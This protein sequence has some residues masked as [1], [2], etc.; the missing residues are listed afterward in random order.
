V[1]ELSDHAWVEVT[2]APRYA[3]GGQ[4]VTVE[5]V[6]DATARRRVVLDGEPVSDSAWQVRHIV[7]TH[8][9]CVIATASQEPTEVQIVRFGFDGT[10]EPLTS[11]AA[12]HSAWVGGPTTVIARTDLASVESSVVVNGE[13]AHPIQVVSHPAPFTPSVQLL[14]AGPDEL[15][16]AVLFPRNH[17][18]GSL[19]LPILMNPYGGPHA[20]RVL[21][22]ARMFLEPQWLADQGFC[23]IVADGRGTPGRD[24]AWERTVLHDLATPA[25]H[26]QVTALSHV[27]DRFP[28][29]VDPNRVGIF[30][31]SFGGYLAALAV[32]RRPDV[33]HAAVAGAP[34]TEWRLY[35][36]AYTERYLGDPNEAPERYDANSLLPLASE[37]KRPLLLV[38]GLADDNVFAAHTLRLSAALLAA[39]RQHS[40]LPL[41]GVTHMTTAEDV[42]ENLALLQLDFL[43]KA[44]ATD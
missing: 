1:R 2:S 7:S 32:L 30:G 44:L 38:H 33:F 25:L 12:V 14:R 18:P 26:D 37:L 31:W 5:D 24:A 20:Q 8:P 11:G 39:G 22:S 42:A 29:D 35:D 27:A 36:T 9:D 13:R 4:L 40:V 16:T 3:E 41:T 23:V 21:A 6:H 34:V 15:R 19:R 28:D 10:W 43:Q 17:E